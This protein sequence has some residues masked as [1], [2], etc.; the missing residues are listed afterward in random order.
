METFGPGRGE[1]RS[2]LLPPSQAP[3]NEHLPHRQAGLL[4]WL[5]TH[6]QAMS[7]DVLHP[8]A[9]RPRGSQLLAHLHPCQSER[10]GSPGKRGVWWA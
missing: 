6:Q 1:I 9:K 4:L 10:A 5:P 3:P 7:C 2:D 8:E